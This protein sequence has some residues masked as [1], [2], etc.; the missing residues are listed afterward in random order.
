MVHAAYP[1]VL[2][3]LGDAVDGPAVQPV[4][5]LGGVLD[6]QAGLDVLDGGGDEADGGAGEDAGHAVAV[7]GQRARGVVQ[8]V[9]R[10]VEEVVAQQAAVDGQRAEHD[11]VHEHPANQGRGR[12]LV[13][14]QYAFVA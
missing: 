4:G 14:A 13:E 9:P 7:R 11:A 1:V 10:R 5:L 6:L 12:A 2:V 3:D 8:G